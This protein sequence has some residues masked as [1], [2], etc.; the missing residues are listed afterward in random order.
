MMLVYGVN[1]SRSLTYSHSERT[2]MIHR[3]QSSHPAES[4]KSV[5]MKLSTGKING[6]AHL[7]WCLEGKKTPDVGY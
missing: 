3:L 5:P 6:F 7:G 4:E 1:E 2:D